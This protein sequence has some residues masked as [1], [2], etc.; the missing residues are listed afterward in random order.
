MG[1][2]NRYKNV[3]IIVMLLLFVAPQNNPKAQQTSN[4]DVN[5]VLAID[6][7]YSVDGQEYALQMAGMAAAFINPAIVRAIENGA[8]GAIA[9]TVVQWSHPDSQ[10]IVVPWKR[11]SSGS[12]ALE[13]A[14]AIAGASRQ[15][16]EGATSISGVLKFG[17]RL[18]Q[19]S[20]FSA[21]RNIIDVVADGENNNGERVEQVRDRLNAS[22]ITINGLAIQNEVSYLYYYMR[23]RVIGGNY[24]FVEQ[25]ASYHDFGRAIHRKL[26][27][28][29]HG[30]PI[31]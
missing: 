1:F 21:T 4:V 11:V 29:I 30:V 17:Q 5:L 16:S 13:L 26:L 3:T 19:S 2:F 28:E 6:C 22:G 24:A 10:I 12:E 14:G 27:R 31:S 23:N 7:S 18:I 25:A 20:P 15:T 9:V 8:Y